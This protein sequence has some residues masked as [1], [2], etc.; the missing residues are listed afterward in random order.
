MSGNRT[1]EQYIRFCDTH[2]AGWYLEP[3][4]GVVVLHLAGEL[5][6]ATRPDLG[7]WLLDVVESENA[8]SILVN[9]SN[10]SFIDAISIGLIMR[11]R[12]A[13]KMRGRLLQVDG[14]QGL[15]AQMFKVLGLEAVV[16]PSAPSP[17]TEVTSGRA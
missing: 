13:A 11:A 3:G 1:L 2:R 12:A 15:H 7:R 9:L 16:R 8:G 4:N 10:V 14:L 5:D 17:T 6:V